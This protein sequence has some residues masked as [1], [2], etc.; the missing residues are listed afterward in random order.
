MTVEEQSIQIKNVKKFESGMVV[1]P[2]TISPEM[3]ISAAIELMML[4]KISG[5]PVVDKKLN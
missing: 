5:I 1:D 2:I 3:D 4:H